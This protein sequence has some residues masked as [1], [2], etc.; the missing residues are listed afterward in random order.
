MFIPVRGASMW[1]AL[2]HGDRACIAVLNDAPRAGDVVVVRREDGFVIHRVIDVRH[3]AVYARGDNCDFDD[4]PVPL[5]RVV[6][7]VEIVAR[8][9]LT[10]RKHEWDVGPR[11]VGRLR[12]RVSRMLA[13][14]ARRL[15]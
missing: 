6:G 7:R 9:N 11:L 15:R 2:Q 3:D 1:P 5:T 10:L 13:Q 12:L 14:L 8:R 4:P